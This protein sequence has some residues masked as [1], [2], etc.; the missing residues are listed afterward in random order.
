MRV[1]RFIVGVALLLA[2]LF[3]LDRAIDAEKAARKEKV[4]NSAINAANNVA[5]AI[6]S[7]TK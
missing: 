4:V 7:V 6:R 3:V 5:D 1:P 2:G